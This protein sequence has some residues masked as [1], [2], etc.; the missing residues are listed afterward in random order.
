MKK[1]SLISFSLFFLSSCICDRAQ[2]EDL[3]HQLIIKS[4]HLNIVFDKEL[5][6]L[7]ATQKNQK[8]FDL[9]SSFTQLKQGKTNIVHD[10][11]SLFLRTTGAHYNLNQSIVLQDGGLII[12]WKIKNTST[13][14]IDNSFICELNI[15]P[16]YSVE[17]VDGTIHLVGPQKLKITYPIESLAFAQ[18]G[19]TIK[20]SSKQELLPSHRQSLGLKLLSE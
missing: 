20:L 3:D 18:E 10:G 15:S 14:N 1:L 16:S 9:S 2:V 7:E 11:E 17:H 19:S 5:H 12:N 13:Q 4:S 6:S 8:I